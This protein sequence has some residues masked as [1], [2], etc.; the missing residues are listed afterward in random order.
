MKSNN[1]I[2]NKNILLQ[3]LVT[4]TLQWNHA[5][6]FVVM[7]ASLWLALSALML[8]D[9][10]SGLTFLL[11]QCY[12]ALTCGTVAVLWWLLCTNLNNEFCYFCFLSPFLPLS[13][14]FSSLFF[15]FFFFFAVSPS[16]CHRLSV[17][18]S[19]RPCG[20]C[21]PVIEIQG[22][23]QP[24][25]PCSSDA[26]PACL[27]YLHSQPSPA[28]NHKSMYVVKAKIQRNSLYQTWYTFIMKEFPVLMDM[29]L[30]VLWYIRAGVSPCYKCF[31]FNDFEL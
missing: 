3:Y 17:S 21:L 14:L 25:A 10:I 19:L 11:Q 13:P 2:N 5:V 9:I 29:F 20:I 23:Y 26:P 18:L 6:S 15:A 8:D 16:H 27:S 4:L 22:K 30:G 1:I 7:F 12:F 28:K 24:V 31:H